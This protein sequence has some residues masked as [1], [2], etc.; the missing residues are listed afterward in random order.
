MGVLPSPNSPGLFDAATGRN[1]NNLVE[2]GSTKQPSN[3]TATRI[4]ENISDR[5]RLFGT[6]T[7]FAS[8]SP[9]QP[10]IPGPPENAIGLSTTTGYQATVA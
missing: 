9:G 5:I 10:T 4:D 2:V 7:H 3:A 6:L 1:A 8:T